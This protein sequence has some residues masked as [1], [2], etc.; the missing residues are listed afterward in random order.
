MILL[1]KKFFSSTGTYS[2]SNDQFK[3]ESGHCVDHEMRCDDVP[4]CTDGTDEVNCS[5]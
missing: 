3:C 1:T 4:D 5:M 2:C